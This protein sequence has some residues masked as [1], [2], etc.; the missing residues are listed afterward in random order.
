[1]RK[2]GLD[3]AEQQAASIVKEEPL[4]HHGSKKSHE[5]V[6]RLDKC[7]LWAFQVC[8]GRLSWVCALT[9]NHTSPFLAI[10]RNQEGAPSTQLFL[11]HPCFD[12]MTTGLMDFS[13]AP[14]LQ[15]SRATPPP[16]LCSHKA[17]MHLSPLTFG[18]H[19]QSTASTSANTPVS[20]LTLGSHP[21]CPRE[22]GFS[23]FRHGSKATPPWL[24]AALR[25][26][27]HLPPPVPQ[28]CSIC[29][30]S[31]RGFSSVSQDFQC[32]I[33]VLLSIA[34]PFIIF[35]EFQHTHTPTSMMLQISKLLSSLPSS[36]FSSSKH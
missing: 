10:N 9:Q 27:L 13:L 17:L 35:L 28:R 30:A 8:N 11:P 12:S 16:P 2:R 23:N 21:A 24:A 19:H 7:L 33:N 14:H 26:W 31:S 4:A 15:M 3:T 6:S 5:I 1:M 29:R 32:W 20:S 25:P 22:G 18:A 36:H 34:I